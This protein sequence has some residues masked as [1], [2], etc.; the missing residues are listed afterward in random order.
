MTS[1]GEH[2]LQRDTSEAQ[3]RDCTRARSARL[4]AVIFPSVESSDEA[5]LSGFASGDPDAAVAFVRR[6]QRRLYGIA[7]MIVGD[8]GAAEEVAQEAFVRA[9]RRAESYDARRGPVLNWLLVITRNVAIDV[10]RLRRTE[11]LDPDVVASLLEL[12]GSQPG[13]EQEPPAAADAQLREALASLSTGHRRALILA[14][15]FGY[16]AREIAEREGIPLGT[17]KTRIRTALLQMRDRLE[18][19]GDG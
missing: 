5:L 12:G 18:V 2:Q 13:S 11:A 4:S 15:Y 17:A 7:L 3:A 16:T 19:R 9:W 1:R 6:F 8:A 10:I 14:A